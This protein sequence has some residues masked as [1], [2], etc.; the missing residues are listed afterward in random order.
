MVITI[1]AAAAAAAGEAKFHEVAASMAQRGL[2]R[3][4]PLRSLAL[5]LS[6]RPDLV[7]ESTLAPQNLIAAAAA[8]PTGGG[9]PPVLIPAGFSGSSTTLAAAP[10]GLAASGGVLNP[11]ALGLPGVRVPTPGLPAG[12]LAAATA[13]TPGGSARGSGA[14][15]FFNPVSSGAGAGDV[16]LIQWRENLAMMA[17]N[18]TAGDV[19]AIVQLGHRLLAEQGQVSYWFTVGMLGAIYIFVTTFAAYADWFDQDCCCTAACIGYWIIALPA[20]KDIV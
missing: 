19:E 6:N 2:L 3:G 8:G 9:L 4:T 14:G 17:A 18:R 13:Y 20:N 1:A 11:G 15:G 10:Q 7:H 5:L 16:L 12:G